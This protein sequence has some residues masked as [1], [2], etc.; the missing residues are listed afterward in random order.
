MNTSIINGRA[1]RSEER[2]SSRHGGERIV[3]G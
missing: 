2:L 3:K 1:I